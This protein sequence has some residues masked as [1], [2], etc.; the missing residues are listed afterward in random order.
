MRHSV[1]CVCRTGLRTQAARIIPL[2]G[3]AIV[4]SSIKTSLTASRHL[5]VGTRCNDIAEET[6]PASLTR[7]SCCIVGRFSNSI[8]SFKS[9]AI[10]RR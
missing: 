8:A 3:D 9:V 10:G 4:L 1:P 7:F 5:V 2:A 6:I